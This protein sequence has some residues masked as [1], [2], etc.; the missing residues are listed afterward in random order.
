MKKIPYILS[1][2]SL[3]LS[4]Q[5][6][7]VAES[8]TLAPGTLSD[9]SERIRQSAPAELRLEGEADPADLTLLRKLPPSVKT[10]D[11]SALSVDEI[12]SYCLTATKVEK[13]ILPSQVCRI[14]QGAFASTPLTEINF[15]AALKS[16]GDHA[17][18][19]CS[20][21][22]SANLSATNLTDLPKQCF[23]GCTSLAKIS[24]P[25]TLR[26]LGYESLMHTSLQKADI[27]MADNIGPYA[28]AYV[29]PLAEVSLKADAHLGEGAF[30]GDSMLS[31]LENSPQE[32]APLS[33]ANTGIS[34]LYESIKTKDI[35]EGAFANIQAETLI[36]SPAVSNIRRH[37]F[38][39]ATKL[40]SVDVTQLGSN[41][42]TADAEAFSGVDTAKIKLYVADNSEDVW[43]AAPVWKDFY[44]TSSTSTAIQNPI[45]SRQV[46]IIPDGSHIIVESSH[47]VTLLRVY[48]DS[49]TI[50]ASQTPGIEKPKAGPFERPSTLLVEVIADGVR[51]IAKI[52]L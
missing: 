50:L 35:A 34:E 32:V 49:G 38:L 52:R 8:Y 46:R 43:A 6:P 40:K 23:S 19:N 42:P 20:R 39:N 37:A 2:L 25:A 41:P 5:I 28:L 4:L 16:I 10:L 14:G 31:V 36:L 22:I 3:S 1:L 51:T 27:S 11:L 21:L 47:P 18:Y 33:L 24:L 13:V 30:F 48:S 15:P 45:D 29:M 12:P 17:F 9:I 44:I 7:A 26:N